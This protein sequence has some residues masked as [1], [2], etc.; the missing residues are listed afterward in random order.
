LHQDSPVEVSGVVVQAL[1]LGGVVLAL[2]LVPNQ[3]KN[4]GAIDVGIF[5]TF[6][7]GICRRGQMRMHC[8]RVN[9][10]SAW[11]GSLR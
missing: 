11:A 10:L 7:I 5:I 9:H 8:W 2:T 6:F 4:K 3:R 1:H